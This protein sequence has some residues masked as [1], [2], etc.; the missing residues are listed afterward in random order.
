MAAVCLIV[1]LIAALAIPG[2]GGFVAIL[3]PLLGLAVLL[4][5]TLELLRVE[6]VY[7]LFHG[8]LALRGPRPPPL[9]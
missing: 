6:P 4:V 1:L 5:V 3:N 2:F 9:R 8:F 7:G